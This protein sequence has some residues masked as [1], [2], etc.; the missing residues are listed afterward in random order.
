MKIFMVINLFFQNDTVM[1][2]ILKKKLILNLV[3]SREPNNNGVW[4]QN[5][6]HFSSIFY[7]GEIGINVMIFAIVSVINDK[8]FVSTITSN[9]P[10]ILNH[11][12]TFKDII[13]NFGLCIILL[14]TL[15]QDITGEINI[16]KDR[17][18][19]GLCSRIYIF[20]NITTSFYKGTHCI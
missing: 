18:T 17:K 2:K 1:Y 13:F 12:D 6:H 15:S 7:F 8:D 20:I 14:K 9:F 19:F 11:F 4:G 5:S 16:K 3:L 10:K